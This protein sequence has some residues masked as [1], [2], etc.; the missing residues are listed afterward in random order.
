MEWSYSKNLHRRK[1]I[2]EVAGKF[3]Q[4][5]CRLIEPEMLDQAADALIPEEFFLEGVSDSQL[6]GL[7]VSPRDLDDIYPLSPMQQG[8]L[9]HTL[10]APEAR[11]Y[12][13]QLSFVIRGALNVDAFR[14]AWH[15]VAER[16]AALRTCFR[17]EGLDEP[18]Q[19]VWR[20]ARIPFEFHDWTH[21][22]QDQQGQEWQTYLE[23]DRQMGFR[24]NEEPL[25]RLA[26]FQL[27]DNSYRLLWSHHHIILDG[28]SVSLVLK[29]VFEC[30]KSLSVGVAPYLSPPGRYRDFIHWLKHQNLAE[31]ER[32]WRRQL[33]GFQ[34]ATPIGISSDIDKQLP[35]RE[36]Y[37]EEKIGL[38]ASTTAALENMARTSQLTL[39]TIL[40]AAYS[41][42]LSR[43]TGQ[44]DVAFGM[45]V[46]G[47]PASL[48]KI[49]SSVGLFV[50]TLAFRVRLSP[51]E[52]FEKWMKSL[53]AQQMEITQYQYT[54][55]AQ[56]QQWCE[57]SHRSPLFGTIFAFENYPIY[58]PSSDAPSRIEISKIHAIDPPQYALTLFA[59]PGEEVKFRALYD[60]R[61]FDAATVHGMLEHLRM[62]LE[63]MAA[64]SGWQLLDLPLTASKADKFDSGPSV[65]PSFADEF[66]FD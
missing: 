5:L 13:E 63:G 37:G 1:T 7:I 15:E 60:R 22:K 44:L 31:A 65:T 3:I 58:G 66:L 25:T 27:T 40:Q 45:V 14:N 24:L 8:I 30:Y 64:Q 62:I 29:E 54:P 57:A 32:F 49:E 59:I 11:L 47:R 23:R 41:I 9:F 43:Y 36:D 56:V 28:W 53:Q 61:L 55:L 19:I 21:Q 42:L 52:P 2:E 4:S 39:N 20:R 17:W 16:H 12:F 48:P 50:N 6:K 38:S 46:S 33:A 51:D 26:L 10:C 35:V 34:A 18:I